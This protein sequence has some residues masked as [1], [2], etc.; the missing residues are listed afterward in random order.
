MKIEAIHVTI[1]I[2]V[3]FVLWWMFCKHSQENYSSVEGQHYYNWMA[4]LENP[5]NYARLKEYPYNYRPYEHPARVH[6]YYDNGE[7][8][9][10]Y[11]D[12]TTAG[13]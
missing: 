13:Y 4:Y 2:L 11:P 6:N 5:T 7:F 9:N 3:L 12:I 10:I 8:N 1:A